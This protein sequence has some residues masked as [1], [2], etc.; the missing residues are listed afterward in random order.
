MFYFSMLLKII[1]TILPKQ[2]YHENEFPRSGGCISNIS[3]VFP[4]LIYVQ[5]ILFRQRGIYQL[6]VTTE[7]KVFPDTA[8]QV[9]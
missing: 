1:E 7:I 8:L 6:L 9:W 3:L 2:Y 5:D 4:R